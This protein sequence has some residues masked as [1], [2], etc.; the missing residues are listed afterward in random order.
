MLT[1]ADFKTYPT[2]IV[3]IDADYDADLQSMEAIA[4]DLLAYSGAATDVVEIIKYI[5]YL[6]AWQSS[7][8]TF[9]ALAGE[10]K[11]V[12]EFTEFSNVQKSTVLYIA[13]NKLASICDANDTTANTDLF[14]LFYDVL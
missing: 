8:S 9:D 7:R 2:N 13:E 6:L 14:M 11:T 3:G 10:Q 5:V 1:F 4:T 12:K